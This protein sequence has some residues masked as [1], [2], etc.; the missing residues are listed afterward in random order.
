MKKEKK[1]RIAS[2]AR[3]LLLAAGIGFIVKMVHDAGGQKISAAL[4]GSIEWLPLAAGLEAIKLWLDAKATHVA[5]SRQTRSKLSMSAVYRAQLIGAAV[6]HVTPSGRSAEEAAKAAVL[7]SKAGAGEASSAAATNQAAALIATGA[8]S[9]LCTVA[10]WLYSGTSWLTLVLLAHSVVVILFGLVIRMIMRSGRLTKWVKRKF[11]RVA[12]GIEEFRRTSNHGGVLPLWPVF[13]QCGARLVQVAQFAVL[14]I[15]IGIDVN[16]A[17]SFLLEGL[18]MLSEVAG[19]AVPGQVGVAEGT[20]LGAAPILKTS[21]AKA[22]AVS[23]SL[24]VVHAFY[25]LVGSLVPYV[26]RNGSESGLAATK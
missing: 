3:V 25:V 20:F 4:L 18:Y 24:R 15:A 13:Y 26:W 9:V 23:L 7:S 14:A 16:V 12:S 11:K 17:K 1:R 5:L 21:G 10:A 19:V 6:G 22:M 2:A 8:V